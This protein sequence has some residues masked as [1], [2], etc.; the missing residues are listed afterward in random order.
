MHSYSARLRAALWWLLPLAAL[1]A[2]LGWET[3]WG[4]AVETRPPTA[5]AIA[6]KPVAVSLLPEYA[7]AGG[8]AART[9]TVERTLFNPTRRPAPA[10][11]QESAQ[12]RMQRG[13]FS[14]TG[15]TMANGKNTAFLRE[16][17]GKSRR[18]QAGDSINGINVAEVKA[19][20][21]KLTLGDESEEL[22]LK[23]AGNPRPT[24]QPAAAPA[25]GSAPQPV[26]GLVQ[27]IPA[28]A[29]PAAAQ[30]AAQTLAERRRAA[31]AGQSVTEGQTP[32]PGGTAA[33]APGTS[34]AA[35]SPTTPSAGWE[36]VYRRYRQQ[37]P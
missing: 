35:A 18:V 21:V 17:T 34:A 9:E 3:D 22:V 2:T 10:L 5:L 6:P 24:A 28:Q 19:D 4:R 8:T 1:A 20:R 14:L 15:T 37:Q 23:V 7:I 29:A 31:R 25:L 26:Q 27:G 36:E 11:A 13:Q 33:P 16:A 12:P 32:L 30:D